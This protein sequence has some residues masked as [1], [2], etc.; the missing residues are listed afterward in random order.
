[1]ASDLSAAGKSRLV[2]LLTD[3]EETCGGNPEQAIR[4][5]RSQGFDVQVNI[6]GFSINDAALKQTFREWAR[7]GGG[8]YFDAQEADQIREAFEESLSASFEV[9]AEGS[10]VGSGS[11]NGEPI[12]LPPGEYTVTTSGAPNKEWKVVIQEGRETVISPR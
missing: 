8:A 10:V 11:V 6:V 3:G 5:L 12:S 7:L 4:E 2:I 1:M 9:R